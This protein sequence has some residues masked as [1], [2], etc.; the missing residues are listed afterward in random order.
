MDTMREGK[1]LMQADLWIERAE[2]VPAFYKT[3][4]WPHKKVVSVQFSN[5]GLLVRLFAELLNQ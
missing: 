4:I 2:D 5:L 3:D 1:F